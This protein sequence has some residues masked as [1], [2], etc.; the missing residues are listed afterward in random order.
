M[1]DYKLKQ[2]NLRA[3]PRKGGEKN[4]LFF[5]NKKKKNCFL[6]LESQS[7]SHQAALCVAMTKLWSLLVLGMCSTAP[8][9]GFFFR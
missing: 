7:H 4:S 8:I 6:N 9:A 2:R 3:S 1:K 5:Q